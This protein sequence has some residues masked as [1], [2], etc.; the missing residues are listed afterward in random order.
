M[1]TVQ[2]VWGFT[3]ITG[4]DTDIAD[5]CQ[6]MNAAAESR[7][8][9]PNVPSD[10]LDVSRDLMLDEA[11]QSLNAYWAIEGKELRVWPRGLTVRWDSVSEA[12]S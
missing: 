2:D 12:R 9:A 11:A 1:A 8:I 6:A 7:S 10:A 4:V 5:F 3:W